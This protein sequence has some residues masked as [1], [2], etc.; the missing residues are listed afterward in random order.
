M[1][2]FQS[3]EEVNEYFEKALA[4]LDKEYE[5]KLLTIEK[6]E[7]QVTRT[8]QKQYEQQKKAIAQ[9]YEHEEKKLNQNRDQAIGKIEMLFANKR[10]VILEKYNIVCEE[11]KKNY[12]VNKIELLE[13]KQAEECRKFQ[14][15]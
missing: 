12:H 6:N 2:S 8:L 14:F 9:Q 13:Q 11:E 3:V 5:Q 1:K 15:Y 7:Q 4:D 10:E